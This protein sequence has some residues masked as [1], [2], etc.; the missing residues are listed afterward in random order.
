M[1][2]KSYR[3]SKLLLPSK[4]Q[5]LVFGKQESDQD[6]ET[7]EIGSSNSQTN[8]SFSEGDSIDSPMRKRLIKMQDIKK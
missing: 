3:N 5:I 8:G 1:E 7:S 6:D 2:S 4:K